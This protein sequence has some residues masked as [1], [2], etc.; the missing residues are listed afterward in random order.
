MYPKLEVNELY[1]FADLT[2]KHLKGEARSV[3]E[4]EK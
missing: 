4:K 3:K 1:V 2:A